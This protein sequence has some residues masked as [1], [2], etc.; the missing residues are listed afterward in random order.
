MCCLVVSSGGVLSLAYSGSAL[1]SMARIK[2]QIMLNGGVFA[3]MAM[4]PAAF[5]RFA[6]YKTAA[7][8]VFTAD[9]DARAI[10][11]E[12]LVM[13]A[14]FCYGWQDN[15][16]VVGDGYWICKN[17]CVCILCTYQHTSV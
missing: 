17:R 14:V 3:S 6:E 10:G 13:H 2:E 4:S 9:E 1:T 11:K 12:D 7:N 8:G 16:R 15:A 5:R